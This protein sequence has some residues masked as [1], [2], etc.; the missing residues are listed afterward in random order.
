MTTDYDSI[1]EQYQL[2][3]RQPWRAD[4]EAYT[5][6]ELVGPEQGS[7]LDIACG[8]GFYTRLVKQRGA[9]RVTGI[10]LSRQMIELARRQEEILDL[11]I[12]YV[13]GDARDLPASGDYDLALAAYFLN[14]AHNR[15]ELQSMCDAVAGVLKP[16]ARFVT[17]NA[18]P[19]CDFSSAPSYR[20]YGFD[21]EALGTWKEGCP[22]RWTFYLDQGPFDIENYY[23]ETAIHEAAL[24][25]AGFDDIRWHRPKVSPEGVE[26]SGRE[27]WADL[28]DHPPITFLEC[29]RS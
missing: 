9:R 6:M 16:G 24:K 28:L 27:H 8:E 1:A 5:L 29:V 11:G 17:V 26:E 18:N 13:C 21:T 15:N 3:K 7:V 19:A 10:D 12:E 22:V 25:K 23:L 2:C 14:Y 4:V 20:K